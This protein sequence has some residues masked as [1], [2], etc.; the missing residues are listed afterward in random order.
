MRSLRNARV[1]T[2]FISAR[3]AACLYSYYWGTVAEEVV[4]GVQRMA[5]TRTSSRR[6]PD[7]NRGTTW[8]M[9]EHRSIFLFHCPFCNWSITLPRQSPLGTYEDHEYRPSALWPIMFLC[10][11]RQQASE[12]SSEMIRAEPVQPHVMIETPAALWQVA[13]ACGHDGC[14]GRSAVYT[15]YLSDASTDRVVNLVLQ[16]NPK[17]RCS[18]SH[19]LQWHAERME[20][21]KFGF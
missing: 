8:R 13:G 11:A 5:R 15:W 19:D 12:C 6:E 18:G 9:M 10:A 20:A 21:M 17:V 16:L 1:L 3:S 14:R 2:I 4:A 7:R